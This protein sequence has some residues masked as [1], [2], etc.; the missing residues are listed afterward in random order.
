MGAGKDTLA[1]LMHYHIAKSHL[2][3]TG[4]SPSLF[5]SIEQFVNGAPVPSKDDGWQTKR[6][7]DKLKECVALI[8]GVPRHKFEDQDFKKQNLP[9]EWD[10]IKPNY[11]PLKP[12]PMTY[13][14]M[15]QEF[16]TEVGRSIHPG[17]WGNALFAD[18]N[19]DS[20]WI[21]TDVRFPNEA[22]RIKDNQGIVVQVI[23]TV[24]RTVGANHSSEVAMDDYSKFDYTILNDGTIEELSEKALDILIQENIL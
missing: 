16:G 19:K 14:E 9:E 21:V 23:R 4:G 6:Y 2:E 11:G 18:F 13:R 10:R 20:K 24:D 7:A 8:L 3:K 15:L 17:F 12:S 1:A 5:P 22:E